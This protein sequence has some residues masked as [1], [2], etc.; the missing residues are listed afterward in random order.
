MK[1]NPI[2]TQKTI[3]KT[4]TTKFASKGMAGARVDEIALASEVNKGMIYHYFGD[5]KGLYEKVLENQMHLM[6]QQMQQPQGNTEWDIIQNVAEDYFDYC[7]RNPEYISLM[8]WEMVSE[9]ETLNTIINKMENETRQF[10]IKT[11]E[12]G[13]QKGIFHSDTNP[14]LFMSLSIVQIFCFFPLFRHPKL[15]HP[16]PGRKLQDANIKGHKK[17]VIEQVMR[18]LQPESKMGGND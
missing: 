16:G 6:F 9:W 8:L 14:I 13:I 12:Q 1:R 18:S 11:I 5:K 17:Q 15:I 10:L 2:K 7:Y 3:L 4:A